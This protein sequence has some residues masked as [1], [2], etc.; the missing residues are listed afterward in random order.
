MGTGRTEAVCGRSGGIG[1]GEVGIDCRP[2]SARVCERS[3]VVVRSGTTGNSLV[4][5]GDS[6]EAGPLPSHT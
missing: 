5:A 1:G 2:V 6:Y 3:A 4:V